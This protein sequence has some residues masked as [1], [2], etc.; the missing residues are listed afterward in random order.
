MN[1]RIKNSNPVPNVETIIVLI[2][3][4]LDTPGTNPNMAICNAKSINKLLTIRKG[5]HSFDK[6]LRIPAGR[7]FCH[8]LRGLLMQVDIAHPIIK[9]IT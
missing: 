3:S 7:V 5:R 8:Q 9:N 4:A 6:N 1:D 2:L